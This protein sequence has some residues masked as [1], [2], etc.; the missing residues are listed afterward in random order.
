MGPQNRAVDS[1]LHTHY[2]IALNIVF[3]RIKRIFRLRHSA[4]SQRTPP[5][6]AAQQHKHCQ[7]QNG[8]KSCVVI[9]EHCLT[10]P[11]YWRNGKLS[12]CCWPPGLPSAVVRRD[13][14]RH[15]AA[16]E[17]HAPVRAGG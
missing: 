7:K 5:A 11:A 13:R 9:E 4:N 8:T 2:H 17:P 10:S 16:F 1:D 3:P 6:S 15:T 12:R 14:G